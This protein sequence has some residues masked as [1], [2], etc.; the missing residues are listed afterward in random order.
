MS[1][2][3]HRGV[4]LQ[5]G[6]G[7]GGLLMSLFKGLAPVLR[8]SATVVAKTALK[9]GQKAISRK[10]IRKAAKKALRSVGKNVV[11]AGLKAGSRALKG[12]NV[13]SGA[14]SDLIRAKRE[15]GDILDESTKPVK[16]RRKVKQN[17]RA[18]E[19]M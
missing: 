4:Y 18:N 12:E 2:V 13:K 19:L 16:K 7:L 11:R 8:K 9:Q 14:K 15:I 5:R 17:N 10:V 1:Y 6:S 3:R